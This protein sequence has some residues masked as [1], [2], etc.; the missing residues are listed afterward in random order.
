MYA[1]ASS[2]GSYL[3]S[4]IVALMTMQ[5]IMAGSNIL[6]VRSTLTIISSTFN[7]SEAEYGG[8]INAFQSTFNIISSVFGNNNAAVDGGVI[9]I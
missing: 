7:N 4:Q 6:T 3:V 9:K 2:T 8:V 1:R 5:L